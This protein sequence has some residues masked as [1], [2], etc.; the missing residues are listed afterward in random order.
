MMVL[1]GVSVGA[2]NLRHL[3]ASNVAGLAATLGVLYVAAGAGAGLRGVWWALVA[4][5]AV[6][7]AGHALYYGT[8]WRRGNVLS[9]A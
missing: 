5:Y 8:T 1:D 4:F 7:V 9:R 2:G 6:R 3:A